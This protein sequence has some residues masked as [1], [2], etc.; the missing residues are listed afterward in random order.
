MLPLPPHLTTTLLK[1]IYSSSFYQHI[2]SGY[3]GKI[4]KHTKR[5]FEEAKQASAPNMSGMLELSDREFKATMI[6]ILSVLM[7]RVDS[8]QE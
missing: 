1:A 6:N 2:M 5:R 4:T 3:Q 7:D 8:M